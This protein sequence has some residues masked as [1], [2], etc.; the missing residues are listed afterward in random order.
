MKPADA[1][2]SGPVPGPATAVPDIGS[3]RTEIDAIDR[4]LAR[5]VARRSGL[6]AAVAAA[7]RAGGDTGFGWRPAREIEIL[8]AIRVA[9]PGLDPILAA[10]IW[11]AMI[12]SNLAA[13]GGLQ[14]VAAPGCEAAARSLVG[15]PGLV[16]AAGSVSVCLEEAA[17][18]SHTLAVL[19]WP[20]VRDDRALPWWMLVQAPAFARLHVCAAVPQIDTGLPPEALVVAAMTPERTGR[21][22]VLLAGPRAALEPFGGQPVARAAG[23]E[24]HA[25]Q[26]VGGDAAS[27]GAVPG[28]LP[29]PASDTGVRVL[30]AYALA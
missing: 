30:G 10:T 13:Q 29:E 22:T 6:A 23:M 3:I 28:A 14:V 9:E 20:G 7:K 17:S 8:R 18:R 15:D 26:A 1:P 27:P 11:R 12:A 5:L 16:Q 2:A 25:L 4:E 24:L 21:D 19:P